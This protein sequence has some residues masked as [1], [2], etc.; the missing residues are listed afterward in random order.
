MTTRPYIFNKKPATPSS[1]YRLRC[2]TDK[3]IE[4]RAEKLLLHHFTDDGRRRRRTTT[5]ISGKF[6]GLKPRMPVFGLLLGFAYSQ[7]DV[8]EKVNGEKE[9]RADYNLSTKTQMVGACD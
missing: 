7:T 5:M 4:F 8:L 6:E 9:A 1:I 3:T 2:R